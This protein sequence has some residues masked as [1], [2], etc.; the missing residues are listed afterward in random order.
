MS[1]MSL[2]LLLQQYPISHMSYL[3][4]L[5]D[6]SRRPYSCCFIGCCFQD[7]FNIAHSILV[8]FPSSFFSICFVDIHVVQSYSRID[9]TAAS[10]KLCFI[11]LDSSHFHMIDNGLL[12]WK[13]L[14]HS[15]AIL[16][17]IPIRSWRLG[18]ILSLLNFFSISTL[19]ESVVVVI[20]F[21]VNYSF[22]TFNKIGIKWL[23]SVLLA[24]WSLPTLKIKWVTF[25]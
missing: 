21:K 2:S 1:L 17:I 23:N 20:I 19:G 18:K 22:N 25:P 10:K 7:L 3:D 16:F 4:G 6:K 12:S 24:N 8:Q 9:T 13:Y 5:R 15:M 14:Y 11:L